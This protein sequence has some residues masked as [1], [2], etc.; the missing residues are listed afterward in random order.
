ML[1]GVDNP[2]WVLQIHVKFLSLG[3][4]GLLRVS[5]SPHLPHGDQDPHLPGLLERRNERRSAKS[6]GKE[7]RAFLSALGHIL[8][9]QPG[10]WGGLFPLLPVWP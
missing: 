3:T 2:V 5:K 4:S 9:G 8:R 10:L 1:A 7:Q 6:V